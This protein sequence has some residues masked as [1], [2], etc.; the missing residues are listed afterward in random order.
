MDSILNLLFDKWENGNPLPNGNQYGC[1]F[2]YCSEYISTR[3]LSVD[4]LNGI[5]VY[6]PISLNSD[7]NCI[8]RKGFFSQNILSLLHNKK[9]KVLLLREHDILAELSKEQNAPN[10][11][12]DPQGT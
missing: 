8:F 11:I 10:S 6:Y 12:D 7:F 3:N 1:T 2:P 4:G 5:N 9:I